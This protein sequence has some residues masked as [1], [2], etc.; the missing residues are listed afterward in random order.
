MS[1]Q[2]IPPSFIFVLVMGILVK[3][4]AIDCLF[5]FR[6][7]LL[8]MNNGPLPSAEKIMLNSSELK[9]IF[10]VKFHG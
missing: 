5:V 2:G 7:L 3:K 1:D 6:P 8:D 4:H 10:F 9:V